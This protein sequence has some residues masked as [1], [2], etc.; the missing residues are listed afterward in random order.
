MA[1][2]GMDVSSLKG[3]QCELFCRFIE[4]Q[5]GLFLTTELGLIPFLSRTDMYLHWL[6][7]VHQ[8]APRG[9]IELGYFLI[10]CYPRVPLSDIRN[11]CKHPDIR[12][13]STWVVYV[14]WN[15]LDQFSRSQLR[16]CAERVHK[17]FGTTFYKQQFNEALEQ[18]AINN[19]L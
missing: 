5:N 13:K 8:F 11:V 4:E 6:N 7:E 18:Y 2:D 9:Y 17:L 19:G 15:T 3:W 1:L 12:D 14:N 16:L 10:T